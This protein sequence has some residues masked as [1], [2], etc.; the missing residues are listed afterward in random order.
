VISVS[1][2]HKDAIRKIGSRLPL[3]RFVHRSE[4]APPTGF[5][6][7]LVRANQEIFERG[8][9]P[10]WIWSDADCRDYWATCTS[11]TPGNSPAE[12]A[13]KATAI[14]DTMVDF[15]GRL[16]PVSA[17]VLEIGS[18]AGPNLER[19]RQIGYTRLGGIEINNSAVEEMRS[20]FPEL[21]TVADIRLGALEQVL[22]Q[23]ASSSVDTVF[24]MAVLHHIHPA[25]RS[26]FAEMVRVARGYICVIEP[27]TV[28]IPYIFARQYGR[29][30]E[31]L[32]CTSIRSLAI[33]PDRMR[34]VD[35]YDGYMARLF[36][37]PQRA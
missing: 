27:E 29:V 14:V 21:A 33:T 9:S 34:D 22:P 3:A 12:Y 32:G 5:D 25:S 24:S 28:T 19:L 16:V 11:E 18:N 17:S 15:W 10:L 7:L 8:W 35:C 2:E 30:F 4:V 20:V 36:R 23:I 13:G 6:R 31:R 1:T 37:V 26:V